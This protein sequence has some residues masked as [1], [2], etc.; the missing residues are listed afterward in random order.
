MKQRSI[1]DINNNYNRYENR[2]KD[3]YIIPGNINSHKS[4]TKKKIATGPRK[5]DRHQYG[6]LNVRDLKE[7][8]KYSQDIH[9]HQNRKH[10]DWIEKSH[11]KTERYATRT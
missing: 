6:F 10:G 4:R 2:K 7:K 11:Q 8:S 5:K 3:Q 9:R 1:N